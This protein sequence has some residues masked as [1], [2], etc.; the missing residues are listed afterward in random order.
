MPDHGRIDVP[1]GWQSTTTDTDQ[2]PAMAVP[3][4]WWTLFD[5]ALLATLVDDALACNPDLR[6]AQA[7][8]AQA[9]A[10]ADRAGAGWWPTLDAG[11]SSRINRSGGT[12]GERHGAALDAAWQPDLTGATGAGVDAARADLAAGSAT[13][14]QARL[15]LAAEVALAYIALRSS[16]AQREIASRN[17]ASLDETLAL[18]GWRADAGL[19]SEL[20]VEQARTSREQTRAQLAVRETALAEA[21]HRLAVLTG[22]APGTVSAQLATPQPVPRLAGTIARGIP[23]ETL[24]QRPDIHAAEQRLIAE[25]ARLRATRAARYPSLQLG[26]S[27]GIEAA[28]LDALASGGGTATRSLLGAISIP[29]FDGG[30][31]RAD[32]AAQLA[33]REQAVAGYE[34]AI[35]AALEDVENALA[36]I[37]GA[38]Q[39]VAA[40]RVANEAAASASTIA[41]HRYASGSIDFQALL[42]SQRT[43]LGVEDALATAAADEATAQVQLFRALGGGWRPMAEMAPGSPDTSIQKASIQKASTQDATP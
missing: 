21:T 39:R 34:S 19:A 20:D 23:A 16:Q 13:Y 31:R 25:S 17:L 37:G 5:D 18:T 8:L 27:L 32:V 9:Q 35:L 1:A 26:G 2:A 12:R 30:R 38:R 42:D 22:R 29:L 4:A 3:E 6:S 7:T 14:A 36:R 40:L 11:L 33:V 15:S 43:A 10:R 41:G 24:R 28:A